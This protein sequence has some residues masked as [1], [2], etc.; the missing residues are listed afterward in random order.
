M[1]EG[2]E[3]RND[4][5]EQGSKHTEAQIIEA[6]KQIEAGRKSEDVAREQGVS[7]HAVYVWRTKYGG[8]EVNEG[9]GVEAASS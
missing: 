3:R 9:R 7:K 6:L 5:Q 8:L 2:R 1:D 4:K